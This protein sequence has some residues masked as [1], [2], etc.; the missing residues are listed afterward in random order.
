VVRVDPV[1]GA[2]GVLGDAAVVL[3]F[4]HPVE[5]ESL[6][7]RTLRVRDGASA[8]DGQLALS[9]DGCVVIW[10]PQRSL[11]PGLEHVL[12]VS[13]V[14][15]RRGRDVRPHQSTFTVGHHSLDALLEDPVG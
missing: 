1:D 15:D 4:S 6:G 14:R 11:R 9:P 13:G 5:P 12:E 3:T 8:V 7:S 10:M 2:A